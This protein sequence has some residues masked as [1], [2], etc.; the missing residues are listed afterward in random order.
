MT[1]HAGE[2]KIALVTG[3][4]SGIGKHVALELARTG[5]YKVWATM[6]NPSAWTDSIPENVKIEKLDVTSDSS[7]A[8]TVQKVVENDGR[9]D[10]LINNAGYGVSGYLETVSID[11]AKAEFEVNVWGAVRMLQAGR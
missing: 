9:I 1:T 6:R 2:R 11:E 7:V 5:E 3:C 4:S 10:V 8:E